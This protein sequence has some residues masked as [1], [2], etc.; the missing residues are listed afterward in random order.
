MMASRVVPVRPRA[1]KSD[2]HLVL[3]WPALGANCSFGRDLDWNEVLSHVDIGRIDTNLFHNAAYFFEL[4]F[5]RYHMPPRGHDAR[6][7]PHPSRTEGKIP[8][9]PHPPFFI[10]T[11]FCGQHVNGRISHSCPFMGATGYANL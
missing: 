9:L 4:G 11:E 1:W 5:P 10:R 3:E 8:F 6:G 7:D 2:R